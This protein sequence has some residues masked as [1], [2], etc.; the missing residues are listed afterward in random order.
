MAEIKIN[1][2]NDQDRLEGR[3]IEEAARQLLQ[4]WRTED[5]EEF[6][7]PSK[8]ANKIQ[9]AVV[10]TIRGEARAIA[11]KVAEDVLAEGVQKTGTY[12]EPRGE[13]VP[14]RAIVA[15]EVVKQLARGNGGVYSRDAGVLEQIVEREVRKV[16]REE[17]QESLDEAKNLVATAVGAEAQK[18]LAVSLAKG[19]P[20]LKL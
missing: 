15:D 1:L 7:V 9:E 12:G 14:V 6:T 20:G 11:P 5:G 19:I 4:T 17:L 10:D 2:E 16:I 3:V 13:K 18:A 8:L